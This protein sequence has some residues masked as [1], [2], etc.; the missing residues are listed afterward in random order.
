LV[1][2]PV[3]WQPHGWTVA[4][5]AGR[6]LGGA[7]DYLRR[8]IDSLVELAQGVPLLKVQICGPM[9][10]AAA[11][12]LPNLHKV[13]TDHGAFRDLASSLA[14]GSRLH[15]QGLRSQLPGTEIV[16]QVDEPSATS[17]LNGQVPTP[18]GYGTV[19]ALSPSIAEPALA[20]V[21]DAAT[22]NCR[23]V[24]SCG[25]EVP[26]SLFRN[27]GANAVS[28]D[29]AVLGRQHLDSIG[30]LLDAGV[31]IW[32]GVVPGTDASIT[33]DQAL[34]Q[35]RDVWQRLGFSLELLAGAVVPTPA[36]GM[37]GASP[38]YVRRAMSV[39]REVGESLLG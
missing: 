34:R 3:E 30:E 39:L 32:L 13:L 16:L 5:S 38:A 1:D 26:F 22:E 33:R 14:E 35:V 12:E 18:S 6:D 10:M 8:D 27:A 19:R 17:V 28:V 25:S 36:C 37:A 4:S 2:F 31:S 11:V 20:A 29:S 21:L 7:R 15:L 9:T 23:V 24:H